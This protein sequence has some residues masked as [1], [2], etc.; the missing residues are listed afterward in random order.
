MRITISEEIKKDDVVKLAEVYDAYYASML[1]KALFDEAHESGIVS[2]V[3]DVDFPEVCKN[4][5]ENK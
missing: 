2:F 3:V 1:M 5:G 4:G